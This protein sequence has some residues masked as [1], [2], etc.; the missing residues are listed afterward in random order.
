MKMPKNEVM[1]SDHRELEE[2]VIGLQIA[3]YSRL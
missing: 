1:E 2:E 3:N